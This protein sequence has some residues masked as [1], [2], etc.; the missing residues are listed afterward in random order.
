MHAIGSIIIISTAWIEVPWLN[1]LVALH[2]FSLDPILSE[3]ALVVKS[4]ENNKIQIHSQGST[5]TVVLSTPMFDERWG[6]IKKCL[7]QV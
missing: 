5:L 6:G 2:P 1:G 3:F 4:L 7:R